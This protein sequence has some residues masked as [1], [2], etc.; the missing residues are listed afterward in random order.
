MT[1]SVGSLALGG[2]GRVNGT[3]G[4]TSSSATNK[5]NTYF[6]ATTGVISITTDTRSTPTLSVTNSPVVYNGSP[7]AV[8]VT[9]SVPGIASNIK[10]NGSSTVPTTVS[11]YAITA[12][13]A[14]TDT[15]T[16][17]SLTAA[18]AGNFV[19]SK[20]TPTLSVTNSPV[21]Y[22]G[23]AHS[24]A[25]SG[26]VP[27]TAS[28]ILTGGAATQTAAGTY[29]VTANFTPTD[30]TNYNSLTA[31]SAGNFVISKATPTLSV[32]N[33]PVVYSAAPQTA[34]VTGSVAGSVSNIKYN[35]S[36]TAPT[37]AGTYAIT[38]D[39]APTDSTDYNSL[40]GASA[41]SFVINKA[42][43]T[44]SVTNSPVVYS[45]APQ[46]AT[47]TGSVAGSVSNIK[48]NGSGTAPTAAGTYAIT[49]DFAPT[50][51]TDYN[52]LTGASAGSFVI[53]K[54]TPTLSVTNSPVAYDGAAHSAAVSGSVPG[55]ASSILTG[56]AATQT[57]AGTYAVTANFTP[58]DTTNYNS[59]TA[60]SAG[61]FVI[62]K[63]TPTLSVTNSPVVYSA[64]PQ[65]ARRSQVQLL[66]VSA[67]LN[68]MVQAQRQ[69]PQA[70]MPLL[71]TLPR[72]ILQITTH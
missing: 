18:S 4:S 31:A 45:A 21:A 44:L 66:E 59:L 41:G 71:L 55:T 69:Q 53:N 56:G 19:I 13:F 24:A 49:A 32:T 57:A 9:G 60:A 29:A 38:A 27:G 70:H 64:A 42:T 50:D 11:T 47:V 52:S 40:T 16:Y 3:W 12:D 10:Y 25:V 20:A 48:Y 54:A 23:A 34:T 14:P 63:A 5:T 33:S 43:P 72:L 68:T 62:S 58:T 1:I 46:T 61:N 51:S 39:F 35:G 17:K 22:D 36:G 26:S 30:T 67:T 2:L 6:A 7:Q 37:A 28:S 65:T 8:S 15:G